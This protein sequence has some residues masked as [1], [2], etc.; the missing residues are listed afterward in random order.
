[1]KINK[2]IILFCLSLF[3][4]NFVS[5]DTYSDC[6]VYGNCPKPVSVIEFN[7]NTG[8]V[9]NSALWGGLPVSNLSSYV[10][11]TGA[12]G[13]VALGIYNLTTTGRV[14][15]GTTNP[16][17]ALDVTGRVQATASFKSTVASYAHIIMNTAKDG[18]WGKI[19]AD[20]SPTIGTWSLAYSAS[21]ATAALGTPVL[22]WN[23]AGN[24]G[25]GTTTPSQKLNVVGNVNITGNLSVKR[26]YAM[27]SST[28]TQTVPL[29]GTAYIMTFNWTENSWLVNK[30]VD[31]AN[32]S[33][34]ATGNYLIELSI[35][36]ISGTPNKHLEVWVQKNGA[37]VP[38]SNTRYEFK[39]A[40]AEAVLA[41]PFIIEL[42]TTDIFRI[43]Y[44][45]DDNS[46]AL[47]YTTNTSY[48]P[49][50]PSAIMTIT[51]L[52]EMTP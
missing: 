23:N 32:I 6:T 52:S 15:I 7:N 46:I 3:L 30:A 11:Y 40:D 18:S 26:P 12:T 36:G 47:P 27:F 37:N 49:E 35:M 50:T 43:M 13:N 4:F 14:G 29:I 21:D 1:M 25:I 20:S 45:G 31:N 38:R 10:P 44:A 24:V 8:N 19:Q 48:S 42:N 5:A 17:V 22:S 16:T 39:G 2:N 33:V 51:K 28:E 34:M 41:V 9:N